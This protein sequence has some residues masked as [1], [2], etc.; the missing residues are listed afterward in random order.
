MINTNDIPYS[1]ELIDIRKMD[2][3]QPDSGEANGVGILFIHGG[4]WGGGGRT[5]FHPAAHYFVERGFTCISASY[6]LLPEHRFPAQFED[7]RLAMSVVRERAA[8]WGFDPARI[9]ACGSSAGGHLVSLLATTAA[10]DELGATA[11]L[12]HRD[13]R[14]Q[15][16]LALC[17]V[18]SVMRDGYYSPKFLGFDQE[19]DEAAFRRAS[20]R[21]RITGNEPPFCMCVGSADTS[22]P[23]SRHQA[24]ASALEEAG[25][26]AEVHTI[27]GEGHGYCYGARSD[28]Q[29]ASLA[30]FHTFLRRVFELG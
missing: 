18:F 17:T 26:S 20:P 4:G 1:T 11:E 29:L 22:T 19:E 14:P 6:R 2:L 27:P 21:H 12:T 13:T 23:L 7:V 16:I 25:G 9:A 24:M 28:G 30:H 3:F 8:D 15:A 5:Q 10:D